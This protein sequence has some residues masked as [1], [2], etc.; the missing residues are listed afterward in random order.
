MNACVSTSTPAPSAGRLALVIGGSRGI[1]AAAARAL[2]RAGCEVWL[3][4]RTREKKA[5]AVVA[6]IAADLGVAEAMQLDVC[7]QASRQA[8]AA[9]LGG[10]GRQIDYLV[11]C[12][13]GGLEP[14]APPTYAEA[15]ND[16]APAA[17]AEILRP[18]LSTGGC[19]I[20]VTSHE[21]H[22]NGDRSRHPVYA[23]IARTK[24]AGERRLVDQEL[25]H[26]RGARLKIVSADI[27]EG[28]ATAKLLERWDPDLVDGHR[29][30]AGR[31]PTPEDVADEIVRRCQDGSSPGAVSYVWPP[32]GR[33]GAA[34]PQ[35]QGDLGPGDLG[36]ALAPELEALVGRLLCEQGAADAPHGAALADFRLFSTKA[37]QSFQFLE[38]LTFVEQ[39]A[40]AQLPES[41]LTLVNFDTPLAITRLI[42]RFAKDAAVVG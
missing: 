19:M 4:Y 6:D 27:V 17:L 32:G 38:L 40:G 1:G 35:S 12:A 22:L 15:L 42:S 14:D 3:T 20:Y 29:R 33:Y 2:A 34:D 31:L 23:K 37:L 28:T 9:R 24:K 30:A 25:G 39:A 21:A 26:P 16:I 36:D 7:S 41:E 8:L 11:L 13:S 18:S 10:D 5:Q